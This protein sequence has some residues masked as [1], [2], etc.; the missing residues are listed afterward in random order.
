MLTCTTDMILARSTPL[1]KSPSVDRRQRW[2][3]PLAPPGC[4]LVRAGGPNGRRAQESRTRMLDYTLNRG[5]PLTRR[6]TAGAT[7]CTTS[8]GPPVQFSTAN[9]GRWPTP[10]HQNDVRSGDGGS[11]NVDDRVVRQSPLNSETRER[12][13][14]QGDARSDGA[15]DTRGDGAAAWLQHC[16]A[17]GAA[18]R[19]RP[20]GQIRGPSARPWCVWSNDARSRQPGGHRTRTVARR[21][22]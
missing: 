19:G 3:L 6:K 10:A 22:L 14:P 11:I 9:H 13:A 5:M 18:E 7:Q 8:G 21:S 15:E 16:V 20:G 12:E 1:S 4:A 2:D 17:S